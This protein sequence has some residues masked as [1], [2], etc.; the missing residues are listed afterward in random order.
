MFSSLES[1][2]LRTAMLWGLWCINPDGTNW[3][4]LVS[5]FLPG[6]NPTAWHFQTQ[7][8]DA[9]I[10]AEEYYSQTSSGFGGFVKFPP[11]APAGESFGPGY[12]L[13]QRN[14]PLRH[15]R[16]DDGKARER[17]LPFSPFGVESLTRFARTDEGP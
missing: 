5:A 10:V 2:G 14:P 11:T 17:R 3:G 13:D 8:S 9:S 4:P 16:L 6:P 12:T 7:L 15:G 1:H